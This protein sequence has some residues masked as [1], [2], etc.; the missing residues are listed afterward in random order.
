[1]HSCAKG[2]SK[3][4]SVCDACTPELPLCVY[5]LAPTPNNRFS[6]Q[7]ANAVSGMLKGADGELV[8]VLS[9]KQKIAFHD[10]FDTPFDLMDARER[11]ECSFVC[12]CV[13]ECVRVCVCVL[14]GGRLCVVFVCVRDRMRK[15][16]SACE[17]ECVFPRGCDR[18]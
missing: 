7:D 16:K 17:G 14:K 5:A 8:E 9:A 2:A 1:M 10:L 11:G 18:E 13:Q 15:R 4:V 3:V 12:A 6:P